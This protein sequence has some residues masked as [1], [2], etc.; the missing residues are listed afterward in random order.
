MSTQCGRLVRA[1]QKDIATAILEVVGWQELDLGVWES[2]DL[3]KRSF[4]SPKSRT[5]SPSSPSY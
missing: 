1:S 2:K 5:R 4:S 3:E